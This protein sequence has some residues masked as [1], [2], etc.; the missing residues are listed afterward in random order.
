MKKITIRQIGFIETKFEEKSGVPI[1]SV[2]AKSMKALLPFS[3]NTL[4]V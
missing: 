1:Q 4:M 3:R 2:L